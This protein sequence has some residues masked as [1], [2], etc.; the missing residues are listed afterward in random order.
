MARAELGDQTAGARDYEG[1]GKN[2][3]QQAFG[4]SP[5]A[6]TSLHTNEVDE[7]REVLGALYEPFE[8]S[9]VGRGPLDLEANSVQLAL[10]TA[11]FIRF[12]GGANLRATDVRSYHISI[13]L[14]GHAMNSW[15]DGQQ[16]LAE[17]S[18]SAAL[19]MPGM[20]TD[21]AWSAGCAQIAL[22]IPAH[23][24]RLQLETMLDRTIRAPVKFEHRLDLRPNSANSWLGL[25][26]IIRREASR[27][28]GLLSHQLAAG[29]LQQLL[30]EGLLLAQPHNYTDALVGG[31]CA[32]SPAVVTR[33]IDLMR[34][35]PEAP[36]TAGK[37][38]QHTGIGAR[39]LTKAFARS[40]E[41]PPMTYLRELRLQRVRGTLLDADPRSVTVTAV[42]GR[43]GFVHL[44]RFAK[45]YHQV[46][47]E[48]PS[49]TLGAGRFASPTAERGHPAEVA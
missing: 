17:A 48:H 35:H 43:W 42:A 11:G 33:A 4:A 2:M 14:E 20:P 47:G 46:F 10:L 18:V 44:G 36:W 34:T 8:I 9:S 38:A 23:E 27:R 7:A 5:L 26:A 30:I 40:G 1:G 16:Q 21:V 49:T 31:V 28:D 24:V 12:G 37:L 41:Q 15:A 32:A 13:P 45:Q 6:C 19:F 25:V 29:N 22:M 39:A 3:E